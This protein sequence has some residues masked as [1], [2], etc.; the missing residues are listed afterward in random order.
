MVMTNKRIVYSILT[1]FVVGCLLLIYIQNIST[2]NI[3]NLIN[4][5]QKLTG[6][7]KVSNDLKELGRN[8]SFVESRVRNPISAKDTSSLK[9]FETKIKK[10]QT[11]LD[12]LQKISDDDTSVKYIDVLDTLV[13]RKLSSSRQALNTFYRAGKSAPENSVSFHNSKK[14][15]DSITRVTDIIENSR[16]KILSSITSFTDE[17]GRKALNLGDI[18]I[19]MIIL[20]G[21]VLFWIII[22]AIRKRNQLIH[23]LNISEKKLKQVTE[24]KEKFIANM[25]HE[26]RT[27]LNAVLGFTNLL[28]RKPLDEESNVYV[29][30]IQKSGE[31]LLTIIN[32]ILDLSKIEAGMV[33]IE[34]M[35][36]SIRGLLHSIEVMLQPKA[37][38][39]QLQFSME[40]DELVPD[41]LEGDP[42]RLTQI[43]LNLIGN[44][45]KFTDKGSVLIRI[46]NEGI[47]GNV[48]NTSI[49]VSDTGI[50]IETGEIAIYI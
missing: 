30:T 48:I 13:Q 47:T 20:S 19:V 18:L 3:N 22:T 44:A 5:D 49:T 46:A 38:E 23:Q 36:F 6:E 42:T 10:I 45:L 8:L 4:G 32:D 27:P 26:I 16:Q 15:D 50:G 40:V 34:S 7:F 39:K 14:L 25:S 17:S 43:L 1:A 21:A 11:V 24:I 2:K 12:N 28:L 31:N 33:R 35:P 29:Q 37:A 41:T 9:V